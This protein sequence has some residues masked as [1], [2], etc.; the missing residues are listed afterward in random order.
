MK[1][2]RNC[3]EAHHVIAWGGCMSPYRLHS[4][5]FKPE[6][7]KQPNRFQR[8]MRKLFRVTEPTYRAPFL[9]DND[10]GL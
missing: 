3:R 5:V 1:D 2:L 6:P 8:A 4:Q 9:N 7:P 10:M